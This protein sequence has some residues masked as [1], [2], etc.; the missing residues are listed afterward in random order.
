MKI[1]FENRVFLVC[2]SYGYVDHVFVSRYVPRNHIEIIVRNHVTYQYGE[3]SQRVLRPEAVV[4]S[5]CSRVLHQAISC[6]DLHSIQDTLPI[7]DEV[8]SSSD[9][10]LTHR[11]S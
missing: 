11:E 5:P 4:R 10:R 1:V 6:L 9:R 8:V 3:V 2:S 7:S